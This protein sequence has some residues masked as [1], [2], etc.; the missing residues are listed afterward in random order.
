[1]V[2]AR[3]AWRRGRG[4]GGGRGARGGER[5]RDA[6]A[7]RAPDRVRAECGRGTG[8][9]RAASGREGCLLCGHR[10]ARLG[11]RRRARVQPLSRGHLADV[12]GCRLA[13]LSTQHHAAATLHRAT[14]R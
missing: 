13:A 3:V 2:L 11:R 6:R 4:A 10:R 5:G 14:R 1:M 9:A 12:L 8:A 7:V